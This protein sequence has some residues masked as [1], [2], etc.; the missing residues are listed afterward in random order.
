VIANQAR[1][2]HLLIITE[3]GFMKMIL[4]RRSFQLSCVQKEERDKA[5]RDR[6]RLMQVVS[7]RLHLCSVRASLI[8]CACVCVWQDEPLKSGRTTFAKHIE[9]LGNI[10]ARMC[11]VP[12]LV[13]ALTSLSYA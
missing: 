12:A 10:S 5:M 6:M 8:T 9:S 4:R 13:A 3:T 2:V 11:V 1:T 7:P